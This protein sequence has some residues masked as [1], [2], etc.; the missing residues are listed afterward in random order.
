M[1]DQKNKLR[2]F[3]SSATVKTVFGELSNLRTI[4]EGGNGLVYEASL[5]GKT[6]AIKFLTNQSSDKITRFKAEFF[7]T[8]TLPANSLIARCLFYDEFNFEGS[9]FPAIGMVKYDGPLK[10]P[11]VLT[12]EG[13]L[14]FFN[15]LLDAVEFIHSFGVIH[16]DLKPENILVDGNLFRVTDF[17]IAYFNPFNF[18]LRAE[19]EKGERLGNRQFSA[20]EQELG[21]TKASAT[22]DIFSIGQLCQWYCTGKVHRGTQRTSI[23]HYLQN[24][25]VYDQ[26]IEKCLAQD[27]QMRFQSIAEIRETLKVSHVRKREADPYEFLTPFRK[28]IAATFPKNAGQATFTD[29]PDEVRRLIENLSKYCNFDRKLWWLDSDRAHL[30]F[31]FSK[32]E[33]DVWLMGEGKYADETRCRSAWVYF[34][35]SFDSDLIILNLLAMEPFNIYDQVGYRHEEA[36]LVDGKHYITRSEYDNGFAEI[37]GLIVDLDDHRVELRNRNLLNRSVLITTPF[38]CSFH[39]QSESQVVEFLKKVD[40]GD[41]VSAQMI[42]DLVRSIRRNKHQTILEM[43]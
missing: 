22:M 9:V 17:G 5:L 42:Y 36:G 30:S 1:Q 15:F 39:R 34:G 32:G 35:D 13:F 38:H 16:R 31:N 19:T 43:D 7:N 6:V 37:E 24:S 29:K 25:A 40:D 33:N 3:L 14:S 26:V 11:D 21:G 20:P 12:I 28:A 18:E 4:G 8:L 2:K 41:D 23:S 27:P 10:R